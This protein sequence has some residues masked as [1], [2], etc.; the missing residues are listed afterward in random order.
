MT[1]FPHRFWTLEADAGKLLTSP[2]RT[3][4][5]LD[6]KMASVGAIFRTY[7]AG[8]PTNTHPLLLLGCYSLRQV[9]RNNTVERS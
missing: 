6:T 1:E 5:R 4:N 9:I 2:R 7:P 8:F 3:H